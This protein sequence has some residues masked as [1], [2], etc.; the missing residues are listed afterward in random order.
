M[1]LRSIFITQSMILIQISYSDHINNEFLKRCQ[2]WCQYFHQIGINPC[3]ILQL[4]YNKTN[5]YK[6][7]Q[8]CV[9]PW[10][11]LDLPVNQGVLGSSPS[12]GAK[13]INRLCEISYKRF[14]FGASF[15]PVF[16]EKSRI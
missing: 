3:N 4:R 16:E 2:L 1:K 9:Y 10:K 13:I 12:W 11:P 15:G 5:W 7:I 14:S 8:I 6:Q